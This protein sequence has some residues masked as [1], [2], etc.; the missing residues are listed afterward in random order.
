MEYEDRLT[1]STPEGV[2]LELTL[3]G[4]GSRFIASMIDNVIQLAI[5]GAVFGAL[6]GLASIGADPPMDAK[7]DSGSSD[8]LAIAFFTLMT[9]GI[10]FLY[11]V[12]FEVRGGG[13]TPGKRMTGLR[14]VRTGGRPVGFLASATRNVLRVVDIL[15]GFYGLAIAC[16]FGT[17]RN[18]RLGDLAAGTIVVRERSGGRVGRRARRKAEAAPPAPSPA[19][20]HGSEGWDVSAVTAEEVATVRTFLDR[21]PGLAEDA[22]ASLAGDLASRLRPRVAGAPEG[23]DPEAFLEALAAAKASR[24]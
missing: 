4:I 3:A 7:A 5:I 15:P 22:R 17:K 2:E 6:F 23:M 16:I 8:A 13:R 14:V 19:P 1:I 9:F 21:R 11:D 10:V 12:L 18:Q 20:S 24:A